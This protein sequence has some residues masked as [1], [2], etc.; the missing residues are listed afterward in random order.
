MKNE[1]FASLKKPIILLIIATVIIIGH[2]AKI[3]IPIE[4]AIIQIVSPIQKTSMAIISSI[5]KIGIVKKFQLDLLAKNIE[6][7]N[8]IKKLLV[9]NLE[10]K[11]QLHEMRSLSKQFEFY[12][13]KKYD[14]VQSSIVGKDIIQDSVYLIL[15]K[16]EREGIKKGQPVV[17]ENGIII[18]KIV[19]TNNVISKAMLLVDTKSHTAVTLKD[20]EKTMG[21]ITGEHGLGMKMELIPQ[22]E[23][24]MNNDIIIT[25]GLEEYV[26]YGLIVGEVIKVEKE[27]NNFFQTAI[28]QPMV[29]YNTLRVVTILKTY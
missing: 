13:Y 23:N 22:D 10:L 24:I 21:I 8:T 3:T 29:S 12:T 14:F 16:G 2:Y 4:N 5:N 1:L 26:P 28:I 15:D 18:A 7:E 27:Q 6:Q 19:E 11:Q 20:K 9:E 17:V 25:S